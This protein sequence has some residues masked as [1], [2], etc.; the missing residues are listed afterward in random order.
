MERHCVI[1]GDLMGGDS[2]SDSSSS[3][4]EVQDQPIYEDRIDIGFGKDFAI[5]EDEDEVIEVFGGHQP[6]TPARSIPINNAVASQPTP[7]P[8]ASRSD[9]IPVPEPQLQ[10]RHSN[11]CDVDDEFE[12]LEGQLDINQRALASIINSATGSRTTGTEDL[13]EVD[14]SKELQALKEQDE[15]LETSTWASSSTVQGAEEPLVLDK[16]TKPS[17]SN[18][19]VESRKALDDIIEVYGNGMGDQEVLLL[20]LPEGPAEVPQ[21]HV[22]GPLHAIAE[23]EEEDEEEQEEVEHERIDTKAACEKPSSKPTQQVGEAVVNSVPVTALDEWEAEAIKYREELAD[24]ASTESPTSSSVAPVPASAQTFSLLTYAEA[25]PQLQALDLSRFLASILP[26]EP[27]APKGWF[28]S[29][30]RPVELAPS[31]SSQLN[32]PFLIA[33]LDYDPSNALHW[34]MLCSIYATLIDQDLPLPLDDKWERLGFQGR[35]PRT[36]LNRSMKLLSVLQML[37]FLQMNPTLSRQLFD[38][39]LSATPAM[40]RAQSHEDKSWPFMCVAVMFTKEALQALRSTRLYK[41]CNTRNSVLEIL[42]LFHQACFFDF[43]L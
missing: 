7:Q 43:G 23:G 15:E 41:H 3:D 10:N 36:D 16:S 30:S 31:L 12:V 22:R 5:T 6:A 14:F 42:N 11:E 25:L 37:A 39:S 21:S 27:V 2:D 13:A 38:L 1:E 4:E 8:S 20:D 24:A 40:P 28:S 9:H 33:Q 18:I 17:S 35:D 29:W 26:A 19:L 34:S 32:F